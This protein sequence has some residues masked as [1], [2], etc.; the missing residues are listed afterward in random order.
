MVM[1]AATIAGDSGA[2]EQARRREQ[3]AIFLD[4]DGVLNEDPGDPG[5]VSPGQVRLI[6]G[7]GAA[8]R[9]ARAA[10]FLTVAVTNRP[11]VAKGLISFDTLDQI[12]GRLEALLAADGGVLD[13]IYSCP[14]YPMPEFPGG[15]PA[16]KISCECRKPGTL[17][18]RQALAD[19]PIDRARSMLVGDSLRDIG[20]ARGLGIWAY[21]VRT[22]YGC[23]DRARYQGE[24]PPLPDLM[25]ENVAEAAA[26]GIGYRTLAAPALDKIR[27][28]VEHKRPPVL[29]GLC[30]RSRAGKSVLA[31]AILRA[32]AEDGVSCL[33]VHL[34]DW[35][36]PLA[37]RPPNA[38]AEVRNRV[39]GLPA[40]IKALRAGETVRAPGYDAATRAI[41]EGTVYDPGGHSVILI[42]GTFAGHQTIRHV[43]DL[44][45]FVGV[46]EEKQRER[47]AAIYRWKG[48]GQR[49]IDELWVERA[50]DEW[51][52]VDLQRGNVDLEIEFG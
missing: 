52:A 18:L 45:L 46:P 24:K 27:S 31:H 40:L 7:A 37:E 13:R 1:Q 47:F 29:V 36:M 8:L 12:F 50:K 6:P 41:G 9:L 28:L 26:F 3:P 16:L 2:S 10:G 15:V 35:I 22:G 25:F 11:Q 38:S 39:E 23:R 32:L 14:H 49:A 17:L 19:L 42:E 51:A 21:G 44:A 5:I 34:D 33:C 20:A 43:L 4:C 30:G 48:L